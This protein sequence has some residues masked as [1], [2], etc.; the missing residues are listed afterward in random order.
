MLRYVKLLREGATAISIL[1]YQSNYINNI[2]IKLILAMV[3]VG[4]KQAHVGA[5]ARAAKP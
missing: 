5:Q 2:K 4:C 1:R 3:F